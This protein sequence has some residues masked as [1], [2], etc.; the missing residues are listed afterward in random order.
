[1]TVVLLGESP[2]T[3]YYLRSEIASAI[4]L[5]RIDGERHGVV[6]VYLQG[7]A[8]RANALYG[9]NLKHGIVVDASHGLDHAAQQILNVVKRR[10]RP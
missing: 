3:A 10:M 2:E 4:S 6:P 9:L 1:M 5:S 8:G 7:E